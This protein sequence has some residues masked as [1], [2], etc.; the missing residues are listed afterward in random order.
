MHTRTQP[1]PTSRRTSPSILNVLRDML[2]LSEKSINLAFDF[3]DVGHSQRLVIEPK[4]ELCGIPTVFS[5]SLDFTP[6][7]LNWYMIL[8]ESSFLDQNSMPEVFGGDY[9][10]RHSQRSSSGHRGESTNGVLCTP[11]GR[12]IPTPAIPG[13]ICPR[14]CFCFSW[15]QTGSLWDIHH[16]QKIQYLFS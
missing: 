8:V 15:N 1:C 13:Q 12:L 11:S 4:I 16:F 10:R 14:L 7:I 3:T 5:L 6:W 2:V 9:N